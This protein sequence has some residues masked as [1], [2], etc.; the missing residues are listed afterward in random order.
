[1]ENKDHRIVRVYDDDILQYGSRI[2]EAVTLDGVRE[3]NEKG[4]KEGF[5]EGYEFG[6]D[7]GNKLGEEIGE[8]IGFV[9]TFEHLTT[10]SDQ[11]QSHGNFTR[12]MKTIEQIKQLLEKF[13]WDNL[14]SVE[15][16]LMSLME[17]LRSKYKLLQIRMG[18]KNT[19]GLGKP[20]QQKQQQAESD[21][22]AY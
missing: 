17:H 1:M 6:L 8:I 22:Y 18:L 10:K 12:V 13:P 3:G 9:Y 16:D 19:P 2:E 15:G 4:E 5:E 20:L 21:P 7:Q 14:T 11:E